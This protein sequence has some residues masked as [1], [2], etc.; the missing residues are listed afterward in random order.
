Q[1]MKLGEP[2]PDGRRQPVPIEGSEYTVDVDYVISAIGQ[3]P[4]VSFAQNMKELTFTRKGTLAVDK[5]TLVSSV[6][7]VFGAG[8]VVT[9]PWT[10]VDAMASGHRAAS[11]IHSY[12]SGEKMALPAGMQG[13]GVEYEIKPSRP[14]ASPRR[15]TQKKEAKSFTG[16]FDEVDEGYAER[17]AVEEGLRCLR[18]GPCFECK[19]CIQ[20][21]EKEVLVFCGSD[22]DAAPIVVRVPEDMRRSLHGTRAALSASEEPGAPVIEGIL[23][24]IVCTVNEELCRGCGTCEEVCLYAAPRVSYRKDRDA[25]I[26]EVNEKECK[27]C[28]T[29]AALCPSGAMQQKHFAEKDLFRELEEH[30][31]AK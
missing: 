5:E 21:C 4:D 27:G 24:D 13:L 18:C 25:L 20:E 8:D 9:G 17:L 2:G 14:P 3:Q 31:V 30:L 19:V 29:C 26:A 7:G 16:N 28:G 12:L 6:E 1:K 22:G 10:V 15:P 23:E 11:A